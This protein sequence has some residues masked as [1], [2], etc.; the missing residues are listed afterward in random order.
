[1]LKRKI[2]KY[3]GQWKEAAD[4]KPLVIKGIRQC[5]KTYIVQKF[6]TENYE[7]VV[8]IN[9]ILEPDKKS[10]FHGNIDVD[11][12]ILNLSALIP[13][14]RFVNGKTCIILD[15]IQECKEARTSL[16]SFCIDGRFDIIATGSLLGVKGYGKT[17]K[18]DIDGGQDSVPVGYETV[19]E[20]FPLDFEEFLWANGIND[21][22]IDN[23]KTCFDNEQAVAEG[24][25]RAMMELLYRYIIVGGTPL[26]P[27]DIECGR[28]LRM[29][30]PLVV[31][32][33]RLRMPLTRSKCI[34][35]SDRGQWRVG[36]SS[37]CSYIA[38]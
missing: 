18:K 32:A 34:G 37:P 13:G 14:S 11:T 4:R 1:M 7:S 6:A 27:A 31:G 15:E 28:R 16:K 26:R 22:V 2:E 36:K 17:P 3:L 29:R 19:I 38:V 10:A 8:Y 23:V 12:I 25:H 21:S 20:M 5:G 33:M 35:Y 9:F 24:I 30:F